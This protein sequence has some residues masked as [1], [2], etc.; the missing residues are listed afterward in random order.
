[1]TSEDER[2]KKIHHP[3][4]IILSDTEE[5]YEEASQGKEHQ[6]YT[7]FLQ[8]AGKL[9]FSFGMRLLAFVAASAFVLVLF[10]RQPSL[11]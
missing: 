11:H 8:K 10:F 9:H 4:F 2:P 3:E 7:E 1:M 6:Q 5:V